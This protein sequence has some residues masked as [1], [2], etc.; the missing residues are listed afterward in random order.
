M[1]SSA[2]GSDRRL[3]CPSYLV[4]GLLVCLP[5]ELKVKNELRPLYES[6]LTSPL[7]LRNRREDVLSVA[8]QLSFKGG[9][10][11]F[12]AR[13]QKDVGIYSRVLFYFSALTQ[14][15]FW[16][17]TLRAVSYKQGLNPPPILSDLSS[18]NQHFFGVVKSLQ[19]PQQ[20]RMVERM[21]LSTSSLKQ[22]PKLC[23]E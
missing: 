14:T 1:N 3:F 8:N 7:H 16:E 6:A 21:K 18:F 20:Y 12:W 9:N 10:S 15:M 17:E 11:S 5:R 4:I 22:M 13:T 2:A 23:L 19:T